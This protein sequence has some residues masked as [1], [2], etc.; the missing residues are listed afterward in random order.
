MVVQITQE[1][2][3]KKQLLSFICVQGK[4]EVSYYGHRTQIHILV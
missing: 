3:R 1:F 4:Y 2:V